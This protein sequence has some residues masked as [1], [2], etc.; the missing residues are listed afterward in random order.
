M[1]NPIKQINTAWNDSVSKWG[2]GAAVLFFS[3]VWG[4]LALNVWQLIIPL[5]QGY[6]CAVVGV[7]D[8]W[9]KAWILGLIHQWALTLIAFSLYA[10]WVGAKLWNV[11]FVTVVMT[12]CM[13]LGYLNGYVFPTVTSPKPDMSCY[14]SLMQQGWIYISWVVLALLCAIMEHRSSRGTSSETQPLV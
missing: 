2:K 5:S 9:T 8:E 10:A 6:D 3:F 1:W 11:A 13:C 14:Q 4:L 7:D 12:L